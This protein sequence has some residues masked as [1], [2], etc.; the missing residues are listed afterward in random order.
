MRSQ[1]RGILIGAAGWLIMAVVLP[2]VASAAIPRAPVLA[3]SLV[4]GSPVAL[5]FGSGLGD[6]TGFYL[7]MLPVTVACGIL[8]WTAAAGLAAAVPYR[9][10]AASL[11]AALFPASI[12][13]LAAPLMSIVDPDAPMWPG[14][15]LGVPALVVLLVCQLLAGLAVAWTMTGTAPVEPSPVVEEAA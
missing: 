13:W 9:M 8:A 15:Y 4:P 12:L 6:W 7:D 1:T 14:D 11:G 3:R 10:V 5:R 2:P